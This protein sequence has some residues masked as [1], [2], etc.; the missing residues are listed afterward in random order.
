MF[1][2]LDDPLSAAPR[3]L[4]CYLERQ[5]NGKL[6]RGKI[7]ETECYTEQDPASHYS[8][9][10]LPETASCL[11]PLPAM[12]RMVSA[13]YDEYK[14]NEIKELLLTPLAV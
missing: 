5:L 8:V 10:R 7:V 12:L 13:D 9:A 6:L 2:F 4:G 3:L 1:D 11:V 14:L